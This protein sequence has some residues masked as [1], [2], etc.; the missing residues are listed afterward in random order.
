M[1]VF[2]VA[3]RCCVGC[4]EIVSIPTAMNTKHKA[5]LLC[6]GYRLGYFLQTVESWRSSVVAM[7]HHSS[8]SL[9][10][11]RVVTES[12]ALLYIPRSEILV[13]RN[14]WGV[15]GDGWM[16]SGVRWWVWCERWWVWGDGW[17][18]ECGVRWVCRAVR[19]WVSGVGGVCGVRWGGMS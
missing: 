7:Q 19:W 15:S 6:I 13:L 14:G 5:Q 10:Q 1:A 18:V 12:L 2:C 17:V 8:S 16:V 3:L 9:F 4:C 11:S